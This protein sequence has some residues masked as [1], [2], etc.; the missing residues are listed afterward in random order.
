[1]EEASAC[2]R[3]LFF[4][5]LVEW[6][7]VS[8]RMMN[9]ST[10]KKLGSALGVVC[11]CAILGRLSSQLFTGDEAPRPVEVAPEVPAEAP[12]VQRRTGPTDDEVLAAERAFAESH[13][14]HVRWDHL[15]QTYIDRGRVS[16]DY[17][18]LAL[19]ED[20]LTRAFA[21][22]PEGAGPFL[23]RAI[24]NALM[25]RIANVDTDLRALESVTLMS[26]NDRDTISAL[27]ADV[28]FY[29]GR[30][31]EAR[32][33]YTAR[34]AE[35]REVASLV[36]LA[37]LEWRT[38]HFDV[39]L[40]L[41]EEAAQLDEG[42]P[43]R[44]WALSVR[45]LLERDR[46]QLDAAL[47][48]IREALAVTPGDPHLEQISAE[49]L[50]ANGEDAAALTRFQSIASRTASPQAMDGAARLLLRAGDSIAAEELITAARQSYETQ[51][52]A[53]P[54]AAYGHAIDHWLRLEDDDARAVLI[55]E[56]NALA[57]PF[58]EP[59]TKLAMAYV[60]A[61]RLED[62]ARELDETLASGWLSAD[63]HAVRAIVADAQGDAARAASER[64]E[65]ERI[66]PGIVSR[67]AWLAPH[68]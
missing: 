14:S 26:A 13:P 30:Y 16:G 58:G 8:E 55:A 28:A 39:A 36:A 45:A 54:E 11:V 62:A 41:I 66:A 49:L 59:R 3:G 22:A 17:R 63:T 50:E 33:L 38:G 6:F 18:D 27:R 61:A 60:R 25:H 29:S 10:G 4:W 1:M 64:E 19:A 32:A 21:L 9:S 42:L 44:A 57:R 24:F 15:A 31:D 53:F 68:P 34:L 47:Q 67:L 37:Q 52:A 43:L 7:K 35:R 51:I 40:P 20:A 2:C 56:G 48:A 12:E 46:G 65:A 5:M 23:R